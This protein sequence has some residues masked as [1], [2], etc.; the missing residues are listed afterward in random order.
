MSTLAANTYTLLDHAKR[1]DPDGG[2][3]DVAEILEQD[4]PMLEDAYW[5]EANGETHHRSTC[6][7]GIPTPNFRKYNEGYAK[8][9]TTTVQVDDRLAMSGDVSEVDAD[10]AELGGNKMQTLFQESKGIIEG[11]GQG[12]A[13]AAIYGDSD[14]EE[15]KFYGFQARYGSLSAENARNVISGSGSGSDLT[16]IYLVG[17]GPDSVFMSYPK[18]SNAGLKIRGGDKITDLFD[19]NNNPYPGYRTYFSMNGGLV[20][21]DWRYAVRICNID[22]GELTKDK[23]GSSADLTELLS[24]SLHRIHKL[25]GVRPCFY[26]NRTVN[27]YLALQINNTTNVN[28]TREQTVRGPVT[29]VEGIPFKTMDAILDTETTVS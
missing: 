22:T 6:R 23:T 1:K 13:D 5:M 20:V 7:S 3:A 14:T 21:R 12:W 26:A 24:R 4:N 25:T 10:L 11:I 28:I 8:K 19:A 29:M 17:W 2:T 18:G 16:S 9:K 15:D 27:E